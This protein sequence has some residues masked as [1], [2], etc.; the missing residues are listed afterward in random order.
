M[1]VSTNPEVAVGIKENHNVLK[2]EKKEGGCN[3]PGNPG[4][5]WETRRLKDFKKS[6]VARGGGRR[7]G[8][9]EKSH[10]PVISRQRKKVQSLTRREEHAGG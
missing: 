9:R 4:T 6:P 5:V 1:E 2:D 8:A 3:S 7:G 10:G